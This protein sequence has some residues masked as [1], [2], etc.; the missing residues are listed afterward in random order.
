MGK[1]DDAG[2]AENE[3]QT[4]GDQ[5]QRRGRGES[6]DQLYQQIRKHRYLGIA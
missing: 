1:V 3:R 4:G 5:K 2:D 6:I